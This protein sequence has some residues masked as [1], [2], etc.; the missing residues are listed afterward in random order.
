MIRLTAVL[1][2]SLAMISASQAEE[3]TCQGP[4][5][6]DTDHARLVAA[7]GQANVTRE[8]VYGPE[9]IESKASVIFS[10][11]PARRLVVTW[12]DEKARKRPAHLDIEGT[13]WS[14]P[15]GLKAGTALAAVEEMNGKPFSLYGFEWDYGGT[16]ADWNGGSLSR[17]P[18]GCRLNIVFEA[19]EGASETVQNKV[20]G[21]SKF[22][23]DSAAMKAAKPRIRSLSFGYPAK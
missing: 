21:D 12:W 3:L 6:K 13:D 2:A 20:A 7:F 23:S 15:Q 4:F 19:D 11:D 10:K 17:L 16:V 1:A 5:A 18:G 14:G 22:T 9:G 8:T